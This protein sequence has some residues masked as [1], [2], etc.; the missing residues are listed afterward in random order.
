MR[1]IEYNGR[2]FADCIGKIEGGLPDGALVDDVGFRAYPQDGGEVRYVCDAD[3]IPIYTVGIVL[4]SRSTPTDAISVNS[5]VVTMRQA[6]LALLAVG[7][8]QAVDD[9][10]NQ[11]PDPPRSAARVTWD[12]SQTVER[13]NG[14]VLQIGPL[15]G[16][17]EA[18]MDALFVVAAQM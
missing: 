6:R 8:L 16:M 2:S 18:E 15:I 7:K 17:S 11:L 12:Y 10:I 4:P 9:A 5:A 1:R 3:G 14:F 13:H